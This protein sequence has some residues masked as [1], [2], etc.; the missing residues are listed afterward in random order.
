MAI[1]Q[2]LSS[3]LP[4]N[5]VVHWTLLGYRILI[6]FAMFRTHGWK[7]LHDFEGTVAN[8]PDP[9]GMGGLASAYISIFVNVVLA[10]FVAVG[11]LTRLSSIGI[12]S[13][14]L[15]GFFI[16]HFQ[17]PWPV[18]DVPLMYSIAYGLLLILGPGSYSMDQWLNKKIK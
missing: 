11:L 18:K 8:I 2:L 17:D 12:L 3:S 16:V 7:K 13:L 1:K 10:F 15:A 14:T 4:S 5:K 9:F 6:A